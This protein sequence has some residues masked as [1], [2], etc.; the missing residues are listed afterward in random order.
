M[1]YF[2]LTVICVVRRRVKMV[3]LALSQ[4]TCVLVNAPRNGPAIHAKK[5]V[6][7]LHCVRACMIMPA[8]T[9][10]VVYV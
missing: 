7:V 5:L 3:A 2:Q 8:N 1:Y 4:A 9:F 10:E 6:S